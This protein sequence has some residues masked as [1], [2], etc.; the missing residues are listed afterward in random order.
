MADARGNI[1]SPPGLPFLGNILDVQ[2]EVPIRAMEHLA[3]VYGP[4][5]KLNL[6]GR[7]RITIASAALLD[8]LMDEKRF[9]KTPGDGLNS[10]Q[11][12]KTANDNTSCP[13]H[14]GRGLFSAP[15]EDDLDWQQAHRTLMPAF[16]PLAIQRM[17]P[18]M[19]DVASQLV[20]KWA[21]MGPSFRIPVTSD[22]T[23]VTLDTIA[24]C[25][26][27]GLCGVRFWDCAD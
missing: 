9:W 24:L 14:S 15:S 10:A 5:F 23:R 4:I 19:H 11:P 26:M 7:E 1:P 12:S 22:F 18:E 8:E 27:V 25:A 3:D 20:L 2:D 17:F 6:M 21:R 13:I 16:G